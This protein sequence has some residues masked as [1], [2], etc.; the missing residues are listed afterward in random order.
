MAY[1]RFGEGKR[2]KDPKP[3]GRIGLTS[4]RGTEKGSSKERAEQGQWSSGHG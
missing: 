2:V 1:D 3:G 4:K